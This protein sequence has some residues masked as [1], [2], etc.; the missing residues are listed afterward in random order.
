MAGRFLR[1]FEPLIKV[2][3]EVRSPRRKVNFNERV[4]WTALGLIIYFVMSEVPLYG[5][6]GIGGD[7]L[8]YYR[9]IFASRRGTLMELGIGPIVT[10]GLILQMLAGS[11]LIEV[12][13]SN[14]DDRALFTGASKVLSMIMTAFEASAY[15]ISGIFGRLSLTQSIIIFIQ[16]LIAGLIIILLDEM[17]QKGWGIGSGISLFILGGVAQ[18]IMIN[19]FSVMPVGGGTEPVRAYGIVPAL[20][21][22]AISGGDFSHLILSK[23]GYPS[24]IGLITT[25]GVFLFVLYAQGVRVELPIAHA[26]FRGFRGR[27]P[28]SLLYVSNLPV[29]FASAL[30]GNIYM[31]SQ[32]LWSR[33]GESSWAPYI[34]F[35]GNF[36]YENGRLIPVGGLAYYVISPTRGFIDVIGNPVRYLIY[37][38]IFVVFCVIFSAIW[39]EVGGLDPRSIAKQLVDSGMQIPGFRRSERPI[40]VILKRYI[41]AVTIL[42]G[43]IVGLLAVVADFFGAYGTGTGILLS[44]S[45]VYQYYQQIMR[46]RLE[47]LYPGLRRFLGG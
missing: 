25:I 42:G 46:E 8:V 7:S 2:M 15:I 27:Y 21:Q 34:S 18:R 39:L 30:F 23:V 38:V 20:I 14:P 33:Y 10:A 9:V 28:I 5:I 22:A 41:P 16:L 11:K 1:A 43:L 3:P 4:F 45:I 17:I 26:R 29:I 19:C 6:G 31:W 40:E 44:V 47:E 37:A 36:T 35:L 13:F 12:D 24:I 32:F